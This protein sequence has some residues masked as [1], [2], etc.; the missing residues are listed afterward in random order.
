MKQRWFFDKIN[1]TD[2]PFSQIKRE[3]TQNNKIRHEKA[4]TRADTNEFQKI[5]RTD[6]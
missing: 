4:E 1:K 6:L 2:K 3:K 5:I